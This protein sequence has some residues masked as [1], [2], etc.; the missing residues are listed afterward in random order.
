MSRF[1]PFLRRF[2]LKV[3]I[4]LGVSLKISIVVVFAG[5]ITIT[6][7]GSSEGVA[8]YTGTAQRSD[9]TLADQSRIFLNADTAV[10]I[11]EGRDKRQLFLLKG[12]VLADIRHDESKPFEVIVGHVV[13][14]DLGTRFDISTHDDVTNVSATAGTIRVY[15]QG[16]DGHLE[17]PVVV[18]AAVARRTPAVLKNGDLVRLE[19]HDGTVLVFRDLNDPHAAQNRTTWL[20]EEYIIDKQRLDEVVWEFN[21]FNQAQIVIDDPDIAGMK[22]GG[23]YRLSSEDVF[24]SNLRLG[25]QLEVMRVD[26]DETHPPSYILRRSPKSAS[27]TKHVR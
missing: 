11:K 5:R 6:D 1:V 27:L 16:K 2:A 25:F 22:L 10:F 3:M 13:L 23:R 20:Q 15:T 9:Y 8:K 24:L 26:A 18:T 4:Y 19:E 21:R 7:T 14:R 12:E 17:D